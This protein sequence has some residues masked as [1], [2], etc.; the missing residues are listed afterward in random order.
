HGRVLDLDI[1]YWRHDSL[2]IEGDTH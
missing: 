2:R 1:E